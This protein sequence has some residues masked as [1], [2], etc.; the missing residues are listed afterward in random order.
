MEREHVAGRQVWAHEALTD[1]DILYTQHGI[2]GAEE[3]L[4]AR[5]A[6]GRHLDQDRTCA[7]AQRAARAFE[8][9]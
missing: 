2:I 1:R 5:V 7:F 4:A 9:G 3:S 6:A 8:G